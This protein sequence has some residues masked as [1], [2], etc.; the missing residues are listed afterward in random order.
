MAENRGQGQCRGTAPQNK[1][2]HQEEVERPTG[3]GE[4]LHCKCCCDLCLELT[5]ARVTGERAPAFTSVEL[6]RL[7]D[8][9]LPQYRML[10]GPPDQQ[11]PRPSCQARL[12]RTQ[13]STSAT[14]SRGTVVSTAT[15]GERGSRAPPAGKRKGKE[16]SL[17]AAKRSKEPSQAAG[18]KG[19]RPGAGTQSQPPPPTSVVQQSEA[20]GDGLEPSPTTAGTATSTTTSTTASSSSPSGQLSEDAGD[21]LEPPPTT[22]STATST[23]ASSSSPSWQLSEAAG[24]GLE[25]PPT[26]ASTA[27]STATATTEQP[28]PPADSV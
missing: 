21:G 18:R 25:P 27:N 26:S 24:D 13:P 6:E 1:G 22:A 12:V 4:D 10:Y 7:V 3:E 15:P 16:Q 23:T 14:Q 9:V 11:P 28:S 19:K 5:M 17:A 8:W 20:A 2:R